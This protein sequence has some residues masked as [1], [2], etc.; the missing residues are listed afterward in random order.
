MRKCIDETKRR[1]SKQLAYN[2][3]HSKTPVSTTGSST[4]SIFDLAKDEIDA[5]GVLEI[6]GH[7][8]TRC[9]NAAAGLLL[10]DVSSSPTRMNVA[11]SSHDSRMMTDH[12]PSS[13]GVYL[14]RDSEN[15]IL[16]I[17]KA[18]NL[19]SRV[20]SYHAKGARHTP[21]ISTMVKK[22]KSIDFMLTPSERDALVL[23]SNLIKHHQPPYNVLLKDDEHYPY[24][25]AS[26]GDT[27]PRLFVT[28]RKLE[29]LTA[30]QNH[31]Y[32]GPYTSF[33]EINAIL[34][35]VE[36]KYDLRAKS[37]LARHGSESKEDYLRLFDRVMDDVFCGS[38]SEAQNNN[39]DS[40]S[41]MREMRLEYEQAGLL[42]DSKFNR[43]RDVVAVGKAK[44]SHSIVLVLV[45]QLRDG[46]V[47]GRFS[48]ACELKAREATEEDYADLIQEVLANR[49]YPSGGESRDGFSWFPDEVLLSHEPAD[50][51][52]FRRIVRQLGSE[53]V[54]KKKS[55]AVAV[56]GTG[57]K[58][59]QEVDNRAIE[60]AVKNANQAAFEKSLGGMNKGLLDG[61]GA[62]ELAKLVK[63]DKSP[64][65]IE[66]YVSLYH[67]CIL[68]AMCSNLPIATFSFQDVSHLQGE[69][70]VA[71]RVVFVNGVCA[72]H[73]Y[74]RFNI[75]SV[76]G[77]DDYASLEEVLE[78]RFLRLPDDDNVDD[79]WILPDLVS[80]HLYL[81]FLGCSL[82]R[83]HFLVRWLSMAVKAN[84]HLQSRV[85]LK[86]VFL[87][88]TQLRN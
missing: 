33:K 24:I 86:R 84:C 12:I 61:T 9:G 8:E 46:I 18:A 2:D 30:Q 36:E 16:Y 62:L 50:V 25:C 38:D 41:T 76:H 68:H 22:A 44:S 49:H 7:K 85:W 72:P 39:D 20:R 67:R 35:R 58:A 80:S 4:L 32:F 19:R 45:L 13:P 1:R 55:I 26:C 56:A 47:A 23:E 81:F 53:A 17:G 34:E 14:W 88:Q 31:R 83:I 40:A 29:G 66:C 65:R 64:A 52:S 63:S 37:F 10:A 60:F 15:K 82:T 74:R 27:F 59:R 87:P 77:I 48:Y 43:S 51:K 79:P 78:R 69:F 70:T 6:S 21:R 5:E 11:A 71:S 28:A 57:S 75:K 54:P 73:L 42:F 3:E